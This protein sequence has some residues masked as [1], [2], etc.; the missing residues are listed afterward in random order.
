MVTSNPRVSRGEPHPL[1]A[2]VVS[3]GVN[4]SLF[5]Q[6]ATAVELLLFD[7]VDADEPSQ[8][9]RLDTRHNRFSN[10]WHVLVHGVGEGQIYAYRVYGPWA[11]EQ[12]H[13]FNPRKVLLDPYAKGIVYT[14]AWSHDEACHDRD[15]AATAMRSLVVDPTRFDWEGVEPPRVDPC[16]RVIYEL[17]VRGFTRH[18]SSGVQ[19]PGTF[20]GLVEK[21]PYLL[22]LGVTTVELL[23]VFQFDEQSNPFRDTEGQPLVDYWGYNPLGFFAPHRGYYIEDWREMRYL[24]GFRDMVK[25]FHRAGLE[26]FLDVVYNHTTEGGETGTTLSFRG[27]E[28]SAYYMLD[29]Q[30]PSRYA[31]YSGC[32][33]TVNSNHPVVRRLILDSLRYWAEV[34]RVD[35]FRFD[36]AAILVRDERGQPMPAP[37]LTWEIESDPILQRTKLVAEAWDAG[38][39]QVGSFPGER[40]AEWNGRF[41][42]DVRRF[43][44]GDQGLA[45]AM[46]ARMLGSPDLYEARHGEP[47]QSVNFVTCHDGFTLNDLVSYAAKHNLAN[48]EQGRDG[49]DANYSANY[50]CEGPS[51]DPEVEA[52]RLRQLKNFFAV[53]LLAQGT[54]MILG[55][56]ELRRSQGGN[57][58]AWCQDNET[59]WV[60]WTLLER[61]AGLHRF[62]RELIRFRHA[63]PNLTRREFIYGVDAPA[64]QDPNGYTRVRW[65]G[66]RLDQPDWS[67][68]SHTLAYTLTGAKDD[69][70]LHVVINAYPRELTFELPEPAPGCGWR[71]A[72]DTSLPSPHDL[73]SAGDE[74]PW[75]SGS[76]PIAGRS[77]VVLVQ[78]P[79]R[80]SV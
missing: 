11:P 8:V 75:P 78:G 65:H 23:P 76:Y 12:G 27:I 31:N 25:A 30:D 46:A 16:R 40:W 60:D 58:N 69:V 49:T 51:D 5:S 59:S 20:A 70:D 54:P 67:D 4:F 57:N 74:R 15:N 38:L 64:Q 28:N 66:V 72:L 79:A 32:G 37:P 34:M 35:G 33:N 47:P 62:V 73:A 42:D 3:D 71:R 18:P 80:S 17:H 45:G 56:D 7:R 10:Y 19:H 9:V 68:A 26:V 21:I 77:A 29:P 6:N 41:R 50:G 63:H 1:G 43:L 61:H 53:L 13:R 48:G 24:T 22:D 2:T 44:R 39:Y 14:E 36:L 52:L 55:G